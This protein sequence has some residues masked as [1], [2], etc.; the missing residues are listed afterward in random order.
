MI[1]L[2][3][4]L[5]NELIV[6][7]NDAKDYLYTYWFGFAKFTRRKK[8]SHKKMFEEYLHFYFI[9]MI[10]AF[11]N[12]HENCLYINHYIV[13]FLKF[14]KHIVW[15]NHTFIVFQFYL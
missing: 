14:L 7:N 9:K 2:E 15:S 1:K 11:L 6:N 4:N 10:F 5:Y 8:N 3:S 13:L 12:R